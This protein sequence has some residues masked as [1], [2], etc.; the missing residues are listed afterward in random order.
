MA[1][2]IKKQLQEMIPWEPSM[3][4]EFVSVSEADK[5]NGSPAHGDMIAMNKDD[6]SDMWLV[7]K[8]YFQDNYEFVGQSLEECGG[9]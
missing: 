4:M 7:A 9:L 6:P 1:F 2:Y 3:V 5:L 8:K